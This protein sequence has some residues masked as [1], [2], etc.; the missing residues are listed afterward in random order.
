MLDRRRAGRAAAL[1]IVA[2]TLG[3]AA[4]DGVAGPPGA[5]TPTRAI[6]PPPTG[7]AS[8]VFI[9]SSP[10]GKPGLSAWDSWTSL[11]GKR[12]LYVMWYSDWSTSFQGF[13]V[14]NAYSR[15][16]TP[17]ITWEMKNRRSEIRY[18]DVLG[19]KWNKYIDGWAAAAKADG[20]PI[21]LRFGH[22]MNGDWYGWSGA[23]NGGGLTAA[24]QFVA[25]WQYVHGRFA[26]AGATN[27]TWVWC[28][29]HESVPNVDW[30]EPQHCALGPSA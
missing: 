13:G 22:E 20:R 2:M 17:V 10:L 27:V 8:G 6:A 11:V 18:A 7:V 29:N 21:F 1:F 15:G 23:R 25:T 9:E 14:S 26:R 5:P 3:C 19:G 16:S 12:S 24:Q 28:V 30:N 4:P